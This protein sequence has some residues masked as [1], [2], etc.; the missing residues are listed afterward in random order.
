M[1][2]L[3][4]WEIHLFLAIKSHYLSKKITDIHEKILLKC[5]NGNIELGSNV[6]DFGCGYGRFS[7]FF[8]KKFNCNYIGVENNEFFS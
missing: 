6:L 7:D 4:K 2:D 8:V 5:L 1:K 3:Q